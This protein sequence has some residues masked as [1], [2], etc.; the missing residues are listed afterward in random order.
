LE[1]LKLTA[2]HHLN[3]KPN[4]LPM[5]AFGGGKEPYGAMRFSPYFEAEQQWVE[6]L[7]ILLLSL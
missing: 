2:V 7:Q 3:E 1:E 5:H 6:E 4:I